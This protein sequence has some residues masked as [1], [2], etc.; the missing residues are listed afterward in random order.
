M[1]ITFDLSQAHTRG[2]SLKLI[3]PRCRQDNRTFSFAHRCIDI[4]NS[5]D[6]SIM[7]VAQLT[8]LNIEPMIFC[9]IEGSYKLLIKLPSL[10]NTEY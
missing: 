5:L 4:W 6:F 9:M 8:G 3:K 2:D 1:V 10:M 7:H